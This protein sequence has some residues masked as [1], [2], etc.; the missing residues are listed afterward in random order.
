VGDGNMRCTKA[1]SRNWLREAITGPSRA[2]RTA[3]GLL[4]AER[5]YYLR[6]SDFLQDAK[7]SCHPGRVRSSPTVGA[8]PARLGRSGSYDENH[9]AAATAARQFD[10]MSETDKNA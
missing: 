6:G 9:R 3:T 1:S 7:G 4:E 5:T 8:R 10:S 2:R